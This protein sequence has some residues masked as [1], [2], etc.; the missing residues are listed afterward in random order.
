MIKKKEFVFD[1]NIKEK[2][3]NIINNLLIYNNQKRFF[4]DEFQKNEIFNNFEKNDKKL[5]RSTDDGHKKE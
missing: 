2:Y 5:M 3:K 4:F 1:S